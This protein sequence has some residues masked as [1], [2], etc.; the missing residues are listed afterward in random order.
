MWHDGFPLPGALVPSGSA[1][2]LIPSVLRVKPG[3]GDSHAELV[4]QMACALPLCVLLFSS[5]LPPDLL[6][7]LS[8][9]GRLVIPH[10]R[11]CQSHLPAALLLPE[12]C[13]PALCPLSPALDLRSQSCSPCL[14]PLVLILP[15]P[16]GL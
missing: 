14:L 1:A 10:A 8:W 11:C 13:C 7:G 12:A 9:A 15:A 3:A 4:E 6:Q 16:H 2:W 5:R